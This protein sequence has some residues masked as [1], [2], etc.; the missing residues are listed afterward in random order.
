MRDEKQIKSYRRSLRSAMLRMKEVATRTVQSQRWDPS[1]VA[2]FMQYVDRSTSDLL[3]SANATLMQL[4]QKMLTIWANSCTEQ[5]RQVIHLAADA[6]ELLTPETWTLEDCDEDMA[7]LDEELKKLKD[8]FKRFSTDKLNLAM[9]RKAAKLQNNVNAEVTK[10]RKIL[11]CLITIHEVGVTSDDEEEDEA[12]RPRMGAV[13]GPVDASDGSGRYMRLAQEQQTPWPRRYRQG[14]E[15]D[16]EAV[17]T[18]QLAP[19]TSSGLTVRI[20]GQQTRAAPPLDTSTPQKRE[21][22]SP[23]PPPSTWMMCQIPAAH[24][25]HT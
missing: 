8:L 20:S 13:S 18:S 21:R 11:H 6:Y 25:E 2:E 23:P 24:Q 16:S 19:R 14:K 22:R 17:S 5:G 1:L 12:S 15:N 9:R 7:E 4:D 3:K 10:A